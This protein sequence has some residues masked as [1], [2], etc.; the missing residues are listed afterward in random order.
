MNVAHNAASAGFRWITHTFS[1]SEAEAITGVSQIVQRDWRRRKVIGGEPSSGRVRYSPIEL[2]AIILLKAF[3]DAGLPLLM[4]EKTWFIA[5]QSIDA[6]AADCEGAVE[7][8]E[9]SDDFSSDDVG[10]ILRQVQRADLLV[11]YRPGF[12]GEDISV[13]FNDTSSIDMQELYSYNYTSTSISI[14]SLPLL[15]AR[16]ALNAKRP[17]YTAKARFGWRI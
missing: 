12:D 13:M 8:P 6:Y 9:I 14:I 10:N 2:A 16:I 3:S 15:G 4:D 11:A 7:I 5:V 1:A 17:L